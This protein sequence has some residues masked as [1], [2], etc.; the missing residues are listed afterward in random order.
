MEKLIPGSIQ[1]AGKDS[2]EKKAQAAIDFAEGRIKVLISKASMFGAG[3]NFQYHCH[4][5]CFVGI[6]DSWEQ[7]YQATA[8]VHRFGQKQE[9]DRH[10]IF[11]SDEF[12]VLENLNRKKKQAD[13]MWLEMARYVRKYSDVAATMRDATAYNPQ[14]EMA[15]PSWLTSEAA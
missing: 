1:V 14:V 15:I 6:D 3:L 2:P 8:R 13:K 7:L 11:S 10:L 9:V 4:R 12:S 5:I